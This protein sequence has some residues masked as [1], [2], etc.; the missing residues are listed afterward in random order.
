MVKE[1]DFKHHLITPA[2]GDA[3]IVEV[4]FHVTVIGQL[5]FRFAVFGKPKVRT[6]SPEET[7][8]SV[9]SILEKRSVRVLAGEFRD[10]LYPLLAAARMR[11]TVNV[12]ALRLLSDKGPVSAVAEDPVWTSFMLVTGPVRRISPSL[13]Q[14]QV[15]ALN[16]ESFE[17]EPPERR[18]ASHGWPVFHIVKEKEAKKT[19]PHTEKIVVFLESMQGHRSEE[20][21]QDRRERAKRRADQNPGSGWAARWRNA[22]S[23]R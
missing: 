23:R 15:E 3:L 17:G 4:G 16:E 14:E 12:C 13:L 18:D 6:G 7:W 8:R 10:S 2:G 1:I 21:R 9:V 11:M 19:L 22:K 5:S 20:K